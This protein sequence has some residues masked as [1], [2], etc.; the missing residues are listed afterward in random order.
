MLSGITAKYAKPCPGTLKEAKQTLNR[1]AQVGIDME[2][3]GQQL[4][5]DGLGF[6]LSRMT[7]C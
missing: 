6:L 7:A 3:F 5:D 1:L 2:R 4:E